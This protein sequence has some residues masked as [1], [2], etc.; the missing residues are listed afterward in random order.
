MFY[1]SANQN[2]ASVIALFGKCANAGAFYVMFIHTVEIYPTTVRNSC[3]SVGS[4]I[5]RVGALISPYIVYL[6]EV[7][8]W[9]K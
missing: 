1:A 8:L 2:A 6:G 5:G 7:V 3:T 9:L 4:A